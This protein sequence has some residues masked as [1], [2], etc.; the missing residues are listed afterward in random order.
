MKAA[1]E[2]QRVV[3]FNGT[4]VAFAHGANP[5]SAY[6]AHSIPKALR[7][8]VD[9]DRALVGKLEI[10]ESVNVLAATHPRHGEKLVT[11]TRVV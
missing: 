10:G 2:G 8:R 7:H 6:W 9:A 5:A 1:A 11:V 3:T 4:W